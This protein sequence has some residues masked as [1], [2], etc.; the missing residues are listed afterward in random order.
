[1]KIHEKIQKIT[2]KLQELNIKK[3]GYNSGYK[4]FGGFEY[5][6]LK[7]FLPPLNKLL[8]EYK[9]MYK[10]DFEETR[11]IMTV[12]NCEND[13]TITYSSFIKIHSLNRKNNTDN[14][15][16]MQDIGATQTYTRR[17]LLINAFGIVENDLIDSLPQEEVKSIPKK[18][19]KENKTNTSQEN[20]KEEALKLWHYAQYKLI[21]KEQ[22]L[23]IIKLFGYTGLKDIEINNAEKIRR[24]IDEFA[25]TK[26]EV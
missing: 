7:D 13:E 11:A 9:L 21:N 20:S 25:K 17:Y 8:D 23:K 5:M 26:K 24:K 6:E 1:M 12:Y 19:Q 16:N 15:I 22:F 18:P 4:N 14:N 3:S 10:I 2:V